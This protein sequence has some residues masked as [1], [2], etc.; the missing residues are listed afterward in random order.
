[1]PS[2][3]RLAGRLSFL[4]LALTAVPAAATC[5]ATQG[6]DGAPARPKIGL[7]L[8]GGGAR[9]GAHI[10]VLKALEDLRVPIDCIAGTSIGAVVGG[11]YATGMTADDIKT[12]L[13]NLDWDA[14]FLD[15]TPRRLRSFRRKRDEDLFLVNLRPG[16][17]HGEI[18]LPIGLVQG[19][20]ADTILERYT[21]PAAKIHDF[22][23]LPI[24]FRAVASNI[25]TGKAVV[26]GT[27][28][29][30]RS[31]RAS[32]AIPAA[33]TPVEIDN[34]LL[35][36]GGIAMNLPVEVARGMGADVII[37]VD[38]SA[39]LRGRE[40]LH[41]VVDV[42]TQLTNLLTRE[43]LE[44]QRSLL[45]KG[46]VLLTPQFPQDL[47]SVDFEHMADSIQAGYDVV[48]RHRAELEKY[49]LP[50]DQYAEYQA[51]RPRSTMRELPTIDFIRLDNRSRIADSVIRTRLGNIMLGK[52]LKFDTIE[53]AID[54]VYGLQLFQ[55]V[56]YSIVTEGEKT[57]VEVQVVPR[58]WGPN[59]LQLGMQYSSSEDAD[60]LFAL[61]ASYL[62]TAIDPLGGE[63]RATFE[64]GDQPAFTMDAYQP[65]G[66]KGLFFVEPSLAF[67][68]K[69]YD[70]FQD[71][72]LLSQAQ[73][74]EATL[75]VS[76]GRELMTW[77]EARGGL[78][79]GY[80]R[81]KLVVGSPDDLPAPKYQRGEFFLRFSADTLDEIAFPSRG[82][83]ASLEWRAS[84]PGALGADRRFDQL[85]LD[86][87]FAKSWGRHTLLST[88]RY[89]TTFS[90]RA[91]LNRAFRFGGFLDLSGLN[92]GQ[93]TGQHVARL[94][95]SYYR[96]IGDLTFLP[97]F[98][99]ISVEIGNAWDDRDA[100]SLS[101]T[102][103]GA[104]IWGGV[105]SPVGP[106]YVGYGRTEGGID[107]YYVYLG[108]VF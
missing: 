53:K 19:Q 48:M 76:A 32:M 25:A 87:T 99:G 3:R 27:G 79:R 80:G 36:D 7:A 11:F 39:S 57:G 2:L 26:L 47:S 77:G 84:R 45:G 46:D 56:R 42:T 81:T 64:V 31:I 74:H 14:L 33:L 93:L 21:L 1:M 61:A 106:I 73:L 51:G 28:S 89:D 108:R 37:A 107:A 59:Y 100:I 72:Q 50:P 17:N 38:I 60:A 105:D 4:A 66:P 44:K 35:V 49:S 86:A 63:W 23:R 65:L 22:D 91:P 34:Q 68:S 41:N 83:L 103:V 62:R 69:R 15:E 78:R 10:G 43:G 98:A 94:G 70:V 8:S 24:P 82:V 54:Q 6:P 18:E 12:V 92:Q 55:N 88:L 58:S 85:L 30:A 16:L 101:N 90:G 104:S 75:E 102:K 9:G 71:E 5:L 13:D 96:R 67:E 29:L 95:A 20:V 97:A 40:A 52:P